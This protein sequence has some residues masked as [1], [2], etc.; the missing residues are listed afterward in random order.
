MVT[1]KVMQRLEQ[2]SGESCIAYDGD[3]VVRYDYFEPTKRTDTDEVILITPGW[4]GS[5]TF[6]G[7]ARCHGKTRCSRATYR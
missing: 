2:K 1:S 4:L 7:V 6:N 5:F 3:K